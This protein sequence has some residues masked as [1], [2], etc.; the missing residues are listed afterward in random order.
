[1][2]ANILESASAPFAAAPPQVIP[3]GFSRAV[4]GR[5][6]MVWLVL[7][8]LLISTNLTSIREFQF[9]D[10]DDA[11]RLVQVR[12]LLAGQ[13][14]FD[15]HQYRSA[16]PEGVLMHWSRLVDIPIAGVMLLLR[17]LL[18]V[19]GAEVAALVGVPLLTLLA[20]LILIGRFA[21]RFFDAEVVGIAC[22]I[23]SIATPV[24]FQFLPMRIDHHAWQIVLA[25]A[26]ACFL[27]ERNA[28]RGG[29]GVGISLAALMAVSIEGLPLAAVFLG[30]CGLRGLRAPETR[31]SWLTAAAGGLAGVSALLFLG[32]R[33]LVD[34]A[35]H[36]DTVSPVHLAAFATGAAGVIALRTWNVIAGPRPLW[37]QIVALGAI[38]TAAGAILL[39]GA[40]Q[41]GTGAFAELDP[42]VRKY[43]YNAIIEGQPVWRF[44]PGAM[45]TM[46]IIPLFGLYATFVHA[47]RASDAWTRTFWL[48]YLLLLGGAYAIGVLVARASGTACALSAV[49]IAALVRDWI[50]ALRPVSLPKRLIGFVGIAFL[51]Q[52]TLP[53]FGYE[54][55]RAAAKPKAAPTADGMLAL[56]GKSDCDFKRA[57][58]LLDRLPATDILAPIDMGPNLLVWS[59]HRVVATGHHRGSKGI[60][61]LLV[62]F[63]S[64]P[65]KAEAAVRAHRAT[66]IVVCPD[67]KELGIYRKAGPD[68]LMSRLLDN[69]PPAWLVPA[70]L[71]PGTGVR[72]WRVLG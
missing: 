25:M 12:D 44:P 5:V 17:P 30:I 43:W 35:N 66:L 22:L 54:L 23:S 41:C 15:L 28:W 71:M 10:P 57:G 19:A 40:P 56:M 29:L 69:K 59:H 7:V 38:G 26:A 63:L 48:D 34:L 4:A 37:I 6:L 60:H 27:T 72:A 47:R 33:G 64:A 24:L 65:E 67:L 13:N 52:P 16:A 62:A 8:F 53:F 21:S 55:A 31:F 68:G 18:G 1:M 45:A 50:V 36:C 9:G 42:L 20:L 2:T 11:L 61:D 32:T 49:P 70:D 51:L 58:Q 46:V 14:W 3:A 39:I